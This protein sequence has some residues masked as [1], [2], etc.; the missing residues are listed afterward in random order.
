MF[1][2]YGVIL[3]KN[4]EVVDFQRFETEEE[5]EKFYQ[6]KKKQMIGVVKVEIAKAHEP[7]FTNLK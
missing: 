2:K 3:T 4:G 7:Y 5:S 6:E 1:K